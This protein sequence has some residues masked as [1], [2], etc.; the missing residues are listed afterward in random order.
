ME[1]TAAAN[2][3]PPEAK[4]SR[5]STTCPTPPVRDARRIW[6]PR[7]QCVAA[8]ALAQT[9]HAAIGPDPARHRGHGS[10]LCRERHTTWRQTWAPPNNVGEEPFVTA[11]TRVT[12]VLARLT[13]SVACSW[14]TS[15]AMTD[16]HA[17][18]GRSCSRID[19][20]QPAE[21]DRR[22]A[23]AFDDLPEHDFWEWRTNAWH[24]LAY[25]DRVPLTQNAVHLVG[26]V[27]NR[28]AG[29]FHAALLRSHLRGTASL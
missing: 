12:D 22:I 18:A 11:V 9:R 14:P 20:C 15:T 23:R 5:D 7:Q 26:V 3:R 2:R 28:D 6:R 24:A 1:S 17:G 13:Q 4:Q 29:M 10:P 25:W 19:N 27:C 21:L 8:L 16:T